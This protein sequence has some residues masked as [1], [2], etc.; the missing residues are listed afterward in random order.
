MKAKDLLSIRHNPS[1]MFYG[2]AGCGKTA[3]VS[4]SPNSYMFDFDDGMLTAAL[5]EDKFSSLRRNCEFDTYVED[6]PNLPKMWMKA[7]RKINEFI[8]QSAKG[9]LKYDFILV[10]SLTG[11]SKAIYLQVMHQTGNVWNKPQIQ[12]WGDMVLM[13]EKALTLLRSLKC[14]LILTAHEMSYVADGTNLI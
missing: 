10:D 2:P 14:P 7:E 12:H 13:M 6:N 11:M 4:Q 5:L 9:A 8:T 1:I 3:L